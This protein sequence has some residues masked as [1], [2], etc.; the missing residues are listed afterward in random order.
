MA[1]LHI[2]AQAN[3]RQQPAVHAAG[4]M[5]ARALADEA[6]G[7]VISTVLFLEIV[8][9]TTK[10]VT[11]QLKAKERFNSIIAD[12][13]DA[14]EPQDRIVFDT[15]NG[16]AIDFLGD[17]QV[18]L[19][20]ATEMARAFA[21]AA[22]DAQPVNARIGVNLGPVRL[23]HDSNGHPN[24]IGDG[25]HVAERVMSLASP[26]QILVSRAFRDAIA[27]LSDAHAL[28]FAY[29]GART[30]HQVREHEIYEVIVDGDSAV[31]LPRAAIVTTASE[32]N[33]R[34]A[35][36]ANAN[37]AARGWLFSPKV[38]YGAALASVVVL[39]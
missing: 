3:D 5:S 22:G 24:I 9:Y 6:N 4:S 10:S 39:A 17:P 33:V 2:A 19:V 36:T 15:G 26:G 29:Q 34:H 27:K 16:A 13:I 18:A 31:L 38:A 21:L 23:V 14:I 37:T 1:K 12:A 32:T 35:I 11:G 25:I 20:I 30:D 7:T 28:L 8:D